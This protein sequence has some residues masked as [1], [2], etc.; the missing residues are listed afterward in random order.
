MKTENITPAGFLKVYREL[1][2]TT[3]D[4]VLEY[5]EYLLLYKYLLEA[6][7]ILPVSAEGGPN[8]IYSAW[9]EVDILPDPGKDMV[10]WQLINN[11]GIPIFD[12]AV[13][14]YFELDD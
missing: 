6:G 4:S 10:V 14:I 7:D 1:L 2:Y 11:I 12:E 3:E 5:P 13:K 9:R 8:W